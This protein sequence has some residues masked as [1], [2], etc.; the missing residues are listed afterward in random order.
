M[1]IGEA[2]GPEDVI[3][4]TEGSVKREEKSGWAFTARVNGITVS[5]GSGADELTAWS[6]VME[7]KAVSLKMVRSTL[8]ASGEQ[9][10]ECPGCHCLYT[11]EQV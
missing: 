9:M 3:V 7:V 11:E 5:E 6:M 8:K 2:S 10:W 1:T 4:F